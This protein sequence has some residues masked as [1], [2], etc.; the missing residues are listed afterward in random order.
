MRPRMDPRRRPSVVPLLLLVMIALQVLQICQQNQIAENYRRLLESGGRPS[1]RNPRPSPASRPPSKPSSVP[2]PIVGEPGGIAQSYLLLDLDSF[3]PITAK[4]L[5]A[6]KVLMQV[7]EPLYFPDP[8]SCTVTSV[9][10]QGH[11]VQDDGHTWI[12]HRR[13]DVT[14]ADGERFDADDVL[15]TFEVMLSSGIQS[16][17]SREFEYQVG[18]ERIPLKV[19]KLDDFTVRFRQPLPYFA[20]L[21]KLAGKMIIPEHRLRSV[22]A[23]GAFQ[24]CWGIGTEDLTSIVGTGPFRLTSYVKGSKLVLEKR[25]DYWRRDA[26]G[27][28]LPYLDQIVLHLVDSFDVALLKFRSGEVDS[29]ADIPGAALP[30]VNDLAETGFADVIDA[31]PNLDYSY[32]MFNQKCGNDPRSGR[33]YVDPVKSQWFCNVEFRRAIAQAVDRGA[34]IESVFNGLAQPCCSPYPRFVPFYDPDVAPVA[35]DLAAA[36]RALDGLGLV[37]R[38]GDGVREDADGNRVSFSIVWAR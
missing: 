1:D 5:N 28:R 11:E 20:F 24:S 27:V 17:S 34:I 19:D 32:L 9:L 13:E 26:R 30:L 14:W 33:P 2:A 29:L 16:Y 15:F 38:D 3:N 7:F 18:D 6:F 36:R 35:F 8:V 37:D 12:V 4:S 10:A 22:F 25:A 31:G 21:E 23:S